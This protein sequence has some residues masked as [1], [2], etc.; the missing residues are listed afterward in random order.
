MDTTASL[1]ECFS[2][3]QLCFSRFPA[4][5]SSPISKLR[6]F[7]MVCWCTC[8]RQSTYSPQ[9]AWRVLEGNSCQA[10]ADDDQKVANAALLSADPGLRVAGSGHGCALPRL[11][12]PC[13]AQ[14]A[15]PCVLK[16]RAWLVCSLMRSWSEPVQE[17]DVGCFCVGCCLLG[18]GSSWQ[19]P[20]PQT[21]R[22]ADKIPKLPLRLAHV[23]PGAVGVSR[24]TAQGHIL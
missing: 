7:W 9:C 6:L 19:A 1:V 16:V 5:R 21:R 11:A 20:G 15:A 14:L 22:L 4:A 3:R 12:A 13:R 17:T 23:E 18:T 10:Q 8:T 2:L 24:R